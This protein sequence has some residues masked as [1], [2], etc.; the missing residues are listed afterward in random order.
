MANVIKV[1]MKNTPAGISEMHVRVEDLSRNILYSGLVPADNEINL[2]SVG[3]VGQGVLIH[4]DNYIS[5]NER[6][7]M[8]THGYAIIEEF[9]EDLVYKMSLPLDGDSLPAQSVLPT[10]V[11]MLGA[12]NSDGVVSS[13]TEYVSELFK[14]NSIDNVE[15]IDASVGG[16]VVSQIYNDGWL[17]IKDLYTGDAS[18]Y[19]VMTDTLGNSISSLRPYATASSTDIES[20]RADLQTLITDISNNGNTPLLFETTF[21]NYINND[22]ASI[23]DESLSSLPFQQDILY[24]IVQSMLPNQWSTTLSRPWFSLYN[25][26]YNLSK[27][28]HNADGIHHTDVGYE[29]LRRLEVDLISRFVKGESSIVFDQFTPSESNGATTGPK[30][31]IL[32]FTSTK[33][34][35]PSKNMPFANYFNHLNDHTDRELVP[36]SGYNPGSIT[37]S[38]IGSGLTHSATN[39]EFTDEGLNPVDLTHWRIKQ[40]YGYV[41]DEVPFELF[42]LKGF[43]PN[44]VVSIGMASYKYGATEDRISQFTFNG[45]VT[46]QTNAKQDDPSNV[47]YVD[48]AADENGEIAVTMQKVVGSVGQWNGCHIIV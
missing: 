15:V 21:R 45:G 32:E 36:L 46:S 26:T 42:T 27:I 39:P 3:S 5:G 47:V 35:G 30:S 31:L 2:G 14:M 16:R 11:V 12:S 13:A 8:A 19:V 41:K 6:T 33:S 29:L 7:F 23:D 24:P 1:D 22:V 48:V 17:P 37:I 18:T 43:K 9:I 4:A 38:S 10:K 25:H 44:Q 40:A 34:T 28:I 20:V